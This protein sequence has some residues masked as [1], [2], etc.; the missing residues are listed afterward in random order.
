MCINRKK[1]Q[2]GPFKLNADIAQNTQTDATPL[3]QKEILLADQKA[4]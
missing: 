3:K 2:N 1:E 4:V